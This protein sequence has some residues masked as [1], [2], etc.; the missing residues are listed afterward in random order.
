MSFHS[1]IKQVNE[2]RH[3]A[4]HLLLRGGMWLSN[5]RSSAIFCAEVFENL[6]F[7]MSSQNG[8]KLIVYREVKSFFKVKFFFL[9]FRAKTPFADGSGG[10]ED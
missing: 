6:V 5:P 7:L 3:M 1:Q 10:T 8:L 2:T 9:S 4:N